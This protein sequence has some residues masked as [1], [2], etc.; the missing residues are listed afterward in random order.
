MQFPLID[1]TCSSILEFTLFYRKVSNQL[2][3]T[4]DKRH[5]GPP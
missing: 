4:R 3:V 5:D 2:G 1:Q